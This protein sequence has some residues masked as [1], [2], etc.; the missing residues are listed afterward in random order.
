MAWF[1][2]K[3]IKGC[4]HVC[5]VLEYM[6]FHSVSGHTIYYL[7]VQTFVIHNFLKTFQK[8]KLYPVCFYLKP[9]ENE[10]LWL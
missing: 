1:F 8:M 4:R 3:H 2:A 10:R 6:H 5:S 9:K 7:H